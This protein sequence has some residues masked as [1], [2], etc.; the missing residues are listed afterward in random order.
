MEAFFRS[1]GGLEAVLERSWPSWAVLGRSCAS[2]RSLFGALGASWGDLGVLL[3]RFGV[4]GERLGEL[5]TLI[6]IMFFDV[7]GTSM[8]WVNMFILAG[9]GPFLCSLGPILGRLGAILAGLGPSWDAL[10][11]ILGHQKC[12]QSAILAKHTMFTKPL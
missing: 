8:F 1:W 4:F 12:S 3:G 7:F 2:L 9:L 11:V 6:F 10:G 5:K